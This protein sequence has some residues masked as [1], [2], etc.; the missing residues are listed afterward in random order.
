MTDSVNSVLMPFIQILKLILVEAIAEIPLIA[1]PCLSV[2]YI[3]V[4]N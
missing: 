3:I 4:L 2:E 1:Y